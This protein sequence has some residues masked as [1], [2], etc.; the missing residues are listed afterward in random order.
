MLL[1]VLIDC[2][3]THWQHIQSE[4]FE[5]QKQGI[6]LPSARKTDEGWKQPFVIVHCW[7]NGRL[8]KGDAP[9]Y[10]IKST[11]RNI[12]T[13]DR[14][15]WHLT[16]PQAILSKW[17]CQSKQRMTHLNKVEVS[18]SCCEGGWNRSINFPQVSSPGMLRLVNKP[19][20]NYLLK[21]L[22]LQTL[23]IQFISFPI[24]QVYLN[25]QRI[26]L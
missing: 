4:G 7:A 19:F 9:L 24:E 22:K 8:F 16:V 6:V 13:S 11:F 23:C 12:I 17:D 2:A 1:S 10:C 26:R 18:A 25:E 5:G 21:L 14:H 3:H 20:W 15:R